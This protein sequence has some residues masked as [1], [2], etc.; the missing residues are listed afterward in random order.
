MPGADTRTRLIDVAE[1]LFAERG[2]NAVSLR[3]IAAAAGQRN[4][5]AVA[6]HFGT[7]ENLVTAIYR[8]RL[9][10]TND[11]QLRRLAELDD[12]GRGEDLRALIEVFVRPM[13]ERVGTPERPS[14]FLRFVANALYVEKL[15]PYDLAAEE[16]TRALFQLH[17]RIS[18]CVDDLPAPVRAHRLEFFIGLLLHTL[19][20]HERH[21]QDGHGA[22]DREL[23]AADL[24]DAVVAVLTAPVSPA[25][26]DHL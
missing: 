9:G 1:R 16:W 24:V 26:R 18:A 23:L 6:Y 22:A 14:W 12:Q 19:A 11:V 25:A 13:I 20:N 4:T 15:A 5:S 17:A 3:E 7:K 8:H 21:V 2:V 10:P